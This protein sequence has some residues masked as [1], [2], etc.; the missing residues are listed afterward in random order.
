MWWLKLACRERESYTEI[1]SRPIGYNDFTFI[2][3]TTDANFNTTHILIKYA[4]K[5]LY[6]TSDYGIFGLQN[7]PC[8]F[9]VVQLPFFV[10]IIFAAADSNSKV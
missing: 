3:N 6:V 5:H 10:V 2:F 4:L 1:N 8:S 7:V 9:I